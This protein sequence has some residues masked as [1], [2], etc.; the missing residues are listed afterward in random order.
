MD[1]LLPFACHSRQ[2]RDIY[3]L[4]NIWNMKMRLYSICIPN[5]LLM[6]QCWDIS[7]CD[8]EYHCMECH[9]I[10]AFPAM[11]ISKCECVPGED[12]A[13]CEI[14]DVFFYV[15]HLCQWC[16]RFDHLWAIYP[17]DIILCSMLGQKTLCDVINEHDT[18]QIHDMIITIAI[19]FGRSEN[20]WRIA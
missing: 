11:L 13:R 15:Y 20:H 3:D 12:C 9:F 18:Y 2:S 1:G 17:F 4:L 8:F 5:N 19:I 6:R 10:G 14:I 7:N 16:I